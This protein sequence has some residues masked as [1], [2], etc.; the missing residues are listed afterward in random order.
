MMPPTGWL[1]GRFGIKLIFLISVT[2]FTLAS[3]LCGAAASLGALVL[4]R[5]LQ[6]VAGPGWFR[7]RKRY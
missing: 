7:C 6:G 3:T 2:G 1:A 5:A 4:F